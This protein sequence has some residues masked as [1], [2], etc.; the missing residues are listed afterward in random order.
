RALT[1]PTPIRMTCS[2]PG[3]RGG[4]V[5]PDRD[6]SLKINPYQLCETPLVLA[7]IATASR[8]GVSV[9]G[10][11]TETPHTAITTVPYSVR[12]RNREL[13]RPQDR[14]HPGGLVP[15]PGTGLRLPGRRSKPPRAAPPRPS[16]R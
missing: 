12:L 7:V 15:A 14:T 2:T 11:R 5:C 6:P 13:A 10:Y 3:R 8:H 1:G 4:L 16:R 9:W